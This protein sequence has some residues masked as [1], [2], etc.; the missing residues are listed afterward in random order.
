MG[1]AAEVIG[2]KLPRA[3]GEDSYSLLP[4]MLGKKGKPIRE[5][6]GHHSNLGMFGIRQGD[7][8]LELGL[9][10]GGFSDPRTEE[11]SAGGPQGQLYNLATDPK[12]EKNLWQ[13]RP[14]QVARLTAL[15][16]KYKV[17]AAAARYDLLYAGHAHADALAQKVGA[18]LDRQRLHAA[19]QVALGQFTFFLESVQPF[20]AGCAFLLQA[21]SPIHRAPRDLAGAQLPSYS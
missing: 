18:L 1:T 19:N 2:Y 8:K 6:V 12:E 4:A 13:E 7:W 10:S 11:P 3:A 15:L 20:F 21:P 17:E 16:E 14:D 5:A 9:G